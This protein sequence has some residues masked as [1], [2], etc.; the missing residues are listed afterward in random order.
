MVPDRQKL[1]TG[2]LTEWTDRRTDDTK[3]ISLRLH[4]GIINAAASNPD[5]RSGHAGELLAV[6][7]A[8]RRVKFRFDQLGGGNFLL[9]PAEACT[10]TESFIKGG[11]TPAY[12]FFC[13]SGFKTQI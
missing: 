6:L 7:M 3:I 12:I 13:L 1:R 11:P 2:G 4:R 9:L 8:Y 5:Y 10:D